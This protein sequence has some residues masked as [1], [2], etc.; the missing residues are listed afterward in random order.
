MT[1]NISRALD[2]CQ[3]YREITRRFYR[4]NPYAMTNSEALH[5]LDVLTDISDRIT[6]EG[7]SK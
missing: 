1:D 5:L 7:D 4:L 6:N 3:L 2:R